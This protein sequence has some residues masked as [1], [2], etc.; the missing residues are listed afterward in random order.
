[1]AMAYL[2]L[3]DT[4]RATGSGD[5]IIIYGAGVNDSDGEDRVVGPAGALGRRPASLDP[6]ELGFEPRPPVR[7]LGPVLLAATGARVVLA[8]QFGAY[9]DKRE[10]QNAFPKVIHDHS[11][12]DDFWLDFVADLGDGFNATYSIAYLLGQEALEVGGHHLPRGQALILGGDQVYP[13]ASAT[14]YEERFRGPYRAALP[15]VPEGEDQ[16]TIYAL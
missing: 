5:E 12:S 6:Q 10:L 7:W 9:L 15:A 3:L 11:H 8:E 2:G 13:T 4:V 16:P 1:T 14:A